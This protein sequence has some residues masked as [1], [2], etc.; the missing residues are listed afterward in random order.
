LAGRFGQALKFARGLGRRF[1]PATTS[2][3]AF[4]KLLVRW[5]ADLRKELVLEYQ[6]V[7]EREFPDHFRIAGY[8]P[9]GGDGSKLQLART[10]SNEARYSPAK[11]RAKK[12]KKRRRTR[13]RKQS[14]QARAQQRGDKKADSPQMA[15]TLLHTT[16]R[17]GFHG[18][19]GWGLTTAANG[20]SCST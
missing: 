20:N 8:V 18:T 6:L 3:Q 19:G 10:R 13:R 14:R 9:L 7:M 5:T 2:Y 16:W 1:A 15:L 4:I 12:G 17:C 11:T